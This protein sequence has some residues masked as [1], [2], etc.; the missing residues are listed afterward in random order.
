MLQGCIDAFVYLEFEGLTDSAEPS[1][2]I[3]TW[4]D[5]HESGEQVL[6]QESATR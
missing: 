2:I 4:G 6:W 5:H 1:R 3:L